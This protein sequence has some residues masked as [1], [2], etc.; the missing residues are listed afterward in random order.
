[1]PT[2]CAFLL[3]LYLPF[4]PDGG[5]RLLLFAWPYFL[6]LI[7]LGVDTF[8]AGGIGAFVLLTI[9]ALSG[10][11]TFYTTPRY[12]DHDYRP[13]IRQV[14]QQ[15]AEGDVLLAIFPWLVGYWRAYAP[16]EL[17]GPQPLL[18]SESALE[19]GPEVETAIADALTR[20]R[21]W[22]PEPLSFG[23]TLP[24]QIE[25]YLANAAVNLEN[26]WY[27]DATRLSAWTRPTMPAVHG[28]GADFGR[29][30]LLAGGASAGPV[31]SANDETITANLVWETSAPTTTL[32]VALRLFD[33]E[34][35]TVWASRDYA[36]LGSLGRRTGSVV[37][38][39]VALNTPVGHAPGRYILSAGVTDHG[40]LLTARLGD[41]RDLLFVALGQVDLTQP[42]STQ[43]PERLPMGVRLAHPPLL[44]GISWLGATLPTTPVLAGTEFPLTVFFQ[45]QAAFPPQRSLYISLLDRNGAGA[46]GWE[47]WPLPGYPTGAWPAGALV[48][49]PVKFFLPPTLSSGRYT[50][51]GG[52]LEESSNAQS[53][54]VTLGEVEIVQRPPQFQPQTPTV[55]LDP[56]PLLGSH[57][58]LVGY[59]LAETSATITLTL[60]WD[61]QQPLLPPHHIFVHADAATGETL[62]QSDGPPA[63]VAGEA[64]TGSWLPGE[65]LATI[66]RLDHPQND[67]GLSVGLY[68]PQTGVRL[69]V[70]ADGASR[71]DAIILTPTR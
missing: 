27:S 18:L 69:P 29:V 13:L 32:G 68:D 23:S 60:Y 12:V 36:P 22:F 45:N 24:L 52:W 6:L 37:T 2:A 33:E 55:R 47:G 56:A 20:G 54:P 39:T 4:F 71:G 70:T 11:V 67:F 66:H 28:I 7:S 51:V 1:M 44:D 48:Q 50:V 53:T 42:H 26:R 63:T 16:P 14:V 34:G 59:D 64:P 58:A 35:R 40:A 61:I 15:G 3:N 49:V 25:N 57:A 38:D 19:Y 21:V 17:N 31:A 41:Q 46:A 65:R 62:T 5:E 30:R 10:V 43:S 9:S 8:G